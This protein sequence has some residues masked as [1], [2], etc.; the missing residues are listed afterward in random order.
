[1]TESTK[2]VR[3]PPDVYQKANAVAEG[4]RT[5]LNA[6]VADVLEREA[7]RVGCRVGNVDAAAS[8]R[9]RRRSGRRVSRGSARR[10]VLLRTG[11]ASNITKEDGAAGAVG[12]GRYSYRIAD[13]N[14]PNELAVSYTTGAAGLV[15]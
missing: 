10:A 9:M 6:Y 14:A 15:D 8:G 11:S 2:C 7:G 5:V 13:A 4:R 12:V 1:M 3:I